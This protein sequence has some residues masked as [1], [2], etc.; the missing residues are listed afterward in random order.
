[1]WFGGQS[2]GTWTGWIK[3][4]DQKASLMEEIGGCTTYRW[5]I[6]GGK[7]L[8]LYG[9]AACKWEGVYGKSYINDGGWHHIA[10]AMTGSS[11]KLWVDG[12]PENTVKQSGKIYNGYK[13]QT[14]TFGKKI[15][16]TDWLH[17]ILDEIRVYR[18]PLSDCEVARI[19][20]N[21]P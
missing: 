10:A 3:T 9:K 15:S 1:M 5:G 12:C 19:A 6:G 8:F 2:V 16:G 18:R 20:K 21:M 11:L 13:K 14:T 7:L 4:T 17:G